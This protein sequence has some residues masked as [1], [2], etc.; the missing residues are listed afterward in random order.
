MGCSSIPSSTFANGPSD[1]LEFLLSLVKNEFGRSYANEASTLDDEL[2]LTGAELREFV[3]AI[4]SGYG[5]WVRD[6]PWDRFG[7]FKP[8]IVPTK[9]LTYPIVGFF[10]ALWMLRRSK[11]ASRDRIEELELGHIAKVLEAGEWIEP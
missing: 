1:A 6:W 5:N 2:C 9:W 3:D 11:A 10:V 8:K 4:A 7:D